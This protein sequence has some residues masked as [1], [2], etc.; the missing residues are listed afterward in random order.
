MIGS[1]YFGYAIC[2]NTMVIELARIDEID[3]E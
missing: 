2:L 1:V 3:L